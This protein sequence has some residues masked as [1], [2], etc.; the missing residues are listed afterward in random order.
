MRRRFPG[1]LEFHVVETNNIAAWNVAAN[2]RQR[3]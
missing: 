2:S 3:F 1:A